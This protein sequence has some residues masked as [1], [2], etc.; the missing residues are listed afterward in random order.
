MTQ[1]KATLVSRWNKPAMVG[2]VIFG[3]VLVSATT[4]S[5]QTEQKPLPV[6]SRC[7][8]AIDIALSDSLV[9]QLFLERV[10]APHTVLTTI[11]CLPIPNAEGLHYIHFDFDCAAG[12]YCLLDP[13]FLV[14]VDVRRRQAKITDWYFSSA[15]ALFLER[16][17]EAE[18][19]A[20]ELS[21]RPRK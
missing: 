19:P 10:L 3:A 14:A 11:E 4:V 16:Y 1:L 7:T 13:G 12:Y 5:A 18:V 20:D 6:D 15:P 8:M 17:R 21:E 2:M 9:R